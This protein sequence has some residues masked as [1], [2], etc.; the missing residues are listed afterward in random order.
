MR[1]ASRRSA[2][3]EKGSRRVAACR[4][5]P[6]RSNP[7]PTPRTARPAGATLASQ[8][9]PEPRIYQ[10]R[11]AHGHD[12]VAHENGHP[13]NST[14]TSAPPSM[15]QTSGYVLIHS[16]GEQPRI[17]YTN[18]AGPLGELRYT[19]DPTGRVQA[20]SGSLAATAL[21]EPVTA[22]YD[23]ANQ[24]TRWATAD[25]SYDAD[26]YLTSDGARSYTWNP[27][28]QLTNVTS[29]D[30][31]GTNASFGYVESPRAPG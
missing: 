23:S 27:R 1:P 16:G 7:P 10:Q 2:D 31:T 12:V 29:A 28:G 17:G 11:T 25:I 15:T 4:A 20:I 22:A 21:P 13:A 3:R 14:T 24:L 19:Y 30:G 9:R 5:H 18:P 26:G 6:A 8:T